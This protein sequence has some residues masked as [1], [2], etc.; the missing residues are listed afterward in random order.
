M[1]SQIGPLEIAIV[2]IIALL[3]LGPKRLPEAGRGLGRS[4]REFKAGITGD[5]ADKPAEA[6]SRVE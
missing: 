5:S 1:F 4:M 2:A 3:V 6:E